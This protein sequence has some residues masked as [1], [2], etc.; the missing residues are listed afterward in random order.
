MIH[1]KAYMNMELTKQEKEFNLSE[2]RKE[3]I[4]DDN[5]FIEY[6]YSEEDIKEFIKKYIERLNIVGSDSG[7]GFKII[8]VD[9]AIFELKNLAGDKFA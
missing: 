9:N 5:E 2:K 8:G 4:G 3:V 7:E 1:N 6:D